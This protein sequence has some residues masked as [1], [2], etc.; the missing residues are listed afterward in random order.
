V[1]VAD[2]AVVAGLIERVGRAAAGDG[3]V[4]AVGRGGG[5]SGGVRSG[6]GGGEGGRTGAVRKRCQVPLFSPVVYSK[7]E[8]TIPDTFSWFESKDT[9]SALTPFPRRPHRGVGIFQ[10]LRS[11]C[12]SRSL[13]STVSVSVARIRPSGEK[14]T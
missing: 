10:N 5:L 2:D 4:G 8:S 7:G 3:A 14:R 12:T 1:E 9:S 13:L 11:G 6:V